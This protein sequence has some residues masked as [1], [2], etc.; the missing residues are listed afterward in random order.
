MPQRLRLYDFRVSRG[1]E[2]IGLCREDTVSVANVVNASQER[3]IYCDEA[4]DEGW[5]GSYAEILFT[6]SRTNP[7][8]TF[9]RE[10]ARVEMVDV[11]DRPIALNNQFFEYLR[12]GNGRLPKTCRNMFRCFPEAFERNE[13][14]SFIDPP[15][16]TFTLRAFATNIVDIE[17]AKRVL[18]QG[19]DVY[20]NV[21]YTQDSVNQITGEY[22]T[23]TTPFS[24]SV[25][26]YSRLLGLQKDVTSG[27]VQIMSV[28]PS[29]GIQ[30][31]ILT[32]EPSEQVA[33][34]RRYYFDSLPCV[35]PSILGCTTPQ[36][37]PIRAIVK[38]DLIPATV[39]QDYLLI[40]SLEALIEEAQ[41]ARFATI[42]G[43]EAKVES[44]RCHK[45]AVKFLNGQLTHYVGKNNPAIEF[46][47]FGSAKLERVRIGMI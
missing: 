40:Q 24:S 3:L 14:V 28:D 47:P 38:L 19:V 42:D 8:V 26:T 22:V 2:A 32:M 34:Y 31:L 12:F 5:W 4:G 39:D 13:A 15:S 23:L 1:P 18:F 36:L 30:T 6:A 44:Q 11:C 43:M 46:S 10:V 9:P 29:T 41:S 16:S 7:F 25:N 20:G 45:A 33:R 27:P 35:C 17:A 37:I 21:V